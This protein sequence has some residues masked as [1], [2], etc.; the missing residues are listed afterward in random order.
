MRS[1]SST[2]DGTQE[3]SSRFNSHQLQNGNQQYVVSGT[4]MSD[5]L[6]LQGNSN[7]HYPCP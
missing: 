4:F 2:V 7:V 1:Q 6:A 5:F 3:G